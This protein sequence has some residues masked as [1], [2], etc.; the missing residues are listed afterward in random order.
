[1]RDFGSW[2]DGKKLSSRANAIIWNSLSKNKEQ[3]GA[4]LCEAHPFPINNCPRFCFYVSTVLIM[5]LDIRVLTTT[6]IF[7]KER[8]QFLYA[9]C[10]F[11]NWF[12]RDLEKICLWSKLGCAPFAGCS[13]LA[14]SP[15]LKSDN[16][17]V[18]IYFIMNPYYLII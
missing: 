9:N 2:S 14:R 13:V 16:G 6:V 12:H 5:S 18:F 15:L 3:T 7:Y 11:F 17:W 1:M 4:V 10:L 8:C